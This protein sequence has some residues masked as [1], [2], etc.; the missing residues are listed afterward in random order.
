MKKPLTGRLIVLD[1]LI[2]FADFA[3]VHYSFD[4]KSLILSTSERSNLTV[5]PQVFSSL[6]AFDSMRAEVSEKASAMRYRSESR[7]SWPKLVPLRINSSKARSALIASTVSSQPSA[8]N[9]FLCPVHLRIIPD[10]LNN[11]RAGR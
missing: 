7:H 6:T 8:A 11:V 10:F 5:L 2:A 1:T 4:S 3:D 9:N